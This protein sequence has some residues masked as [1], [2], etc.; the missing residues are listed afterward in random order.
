VADGAGL[1]PEGLEQARQSDGTE[2]V[3]VSFRPGV[4]E[5]AATRRLAAAYPTSMESYVEPKPP[6]DVVNLSSVDALPWL[7]AGFLVVL[8][9]AA[10]AHALVVSVRRRR[11]ELAVLRALGFRRGQVRASVAWQAS[12][13][14]V[15]GLVAGI[16]LGL[17][18]G[19]WA[20]A[21]VARSI[22]VLDDPVAPVMTL[23][24]LPIAALVVANLTAIA[25]ALRAAS[26]SAA[27]ALRSE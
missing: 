15:V 13:L 9:V 20:W 10:V 16:P 25:P 26:P 12:S 22:G 14:T 7:L 1:T 5:A 27:V 17:A 23:V 2:R 8:A 24:L 18:L 11:R 4:D 6:G 3:V 21:L 19:R